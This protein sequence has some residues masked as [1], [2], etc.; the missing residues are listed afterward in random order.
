MKIFFHKQ[1]LDGRCSGAIVKRL[2]SEGELMPINYGDN[3]PWDEIEPEELVFMVDFSLPYEEMSRL[4]TVSN[5]VW[6]DHHITAMEEHKDLN[7]IGKTRTDV[8]ACHLV[9]EYLF[10]GNDVPLG[11]RLLSEYDIWNHKDLRVLPFHYA[12]GLEY[13]WPDGN[14]WKNIWE[15][16]SHWIS[17]MVVTGKLLLKYER[18]NNRAYIQAFGFETEFE[19]YKAVAVNTGGKNSLLFESIEGDHDLMITFVFRNGEWKIS[20]YA[21]NE[22]VH[23]GTLAQLYGGGGHKGAAG[24]KIKD[25]PFKTL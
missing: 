23:C 20:L 9:W 18:K 1:D 3:F 17:Q 12:M 6:I 24:F 21:N 15:S 7:L 16:N 4:N 11:V 8:A 2:Y 13:T 14:I 5:L 25:L 22:H 10:P 19:G